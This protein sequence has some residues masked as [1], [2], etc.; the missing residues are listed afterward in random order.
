MDQGTMSHSDDSVVSQEQTQ[1]EMVMSLPPGYTKGHS[2]HRY[3][4]VPPSGFSMNQLSDKFEDDEIKRLKV[5][6]SNVTV[7]VALMMLFPEDFDTLTRARKE[8]RRKKI[9]VLRRGDAPGSTVSFDPE[10]M[11]IGRVGDRV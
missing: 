4:T 7:P 10:R 11:S 2:I 1:E 5:T 9:I 3:A 8:C 6:S